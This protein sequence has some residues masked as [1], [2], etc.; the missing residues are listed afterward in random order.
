MLKTDKYTRKPFIIEAVQVTEE[1]MADVATWC[2]GEILSTNSQI[3]QGLHKDPER[4]IKVDVQN[5]MNERQTRAFVGDWV[6][7]ANQGFKVYTDRAFQRSFDPV[8]QE[9]PKPAAPTEPAKDEPVE[10]AGTVAQEG[11]G[12]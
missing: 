2:K 12:E 9:V 3:A 11:L 5:P 1:N 8:F 6:L 10:M 7:F 4:F